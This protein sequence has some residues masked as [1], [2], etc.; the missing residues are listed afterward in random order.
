[1]KLNALVVGFGYWGPNL[2]RNIHQS[3]NYNLLGII[4]SENERASIARATYDV[5]VVSKIDEVT[6]LDSVDIVFI[7]T[8]P[9]SHFDLARFF[10]EEGKNV[11]LP[12]PVTTSAQEAVALMELADENNVLIFCDYTYF[13][14]D[15]F[16]YMNTW[17][18][19]NELLHYTSYRCSLGIL[20][21]DVDVIADLAS[22]DFSMLYKLTGEV[23]SEIYSLDTSHK[24]YM[25]NTTSATI[26]AKWKSGLTADIN[27]SW[28][29]PKKIRKVVLSAP[30]SSLLVDETNPLQQLSIVQFSKNESELSAGDLSYRRNTSFTLGEEKFV[31]FERTE[32]LATEIDTLHGNI[33]RSV[34]VNETFCLADSIKVWEYIKGAQ[35]NRIG[36]RDDSI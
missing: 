17:I 32:S 22:H 19:D 34:G 28:N 20:Q 8:K 9:A 12:K 6:G 11:V 7:A 29:A 24:K 3:P 33:C 26:F 16:K 5:E 4:E 10:I 35:E 27:V 2:A 14:S 21:S 13:Y 31:N 30:T 18:H 25:G 23:P 15:N 36:T 1:M